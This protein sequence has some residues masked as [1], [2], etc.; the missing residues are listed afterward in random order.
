MNIGSLASL[1][2]VG[3]IRFS[4]ASASQSSPG[5]TKTSLPKSPAAFQ[6][7]PRTIQ[8]GNPNMGKMKTIPV[9]GKKFNIVRCSLSMILEVQLL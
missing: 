2:P 4:P 9:A 5:T 6:K 3:P 1:A 7:G 8:M